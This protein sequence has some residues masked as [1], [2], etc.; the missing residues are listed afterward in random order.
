M[1]NT[2]HLKATT[3]HTGFRRFVWPLAT[4]VTMAVA[5]PALAQGPRTQGAKA[6]PTQ[7]SPGAG[8]LTWPAAPISDPHLL[9][10][11]IPNVPG[12]RARLRIKEPIGQLPRSDT[13]K[14]L[15]SNND[16]F[17][18]I[19][20]HPDIYARIN[21]V[22]RSVG[23][24]RRIGEQVTSVATYPIESSCVFDPQ[25][26][27]DGS[28]I[29]FKIGDAF[30]STGTF[31]LYLWDMAVGRLSEVLSEDISFSNVLWSPDS[32]YV[33]YVR[34]GDVAGRVRAKMLPLR[35]R[36]LDL[37]TGHSRHVAKSGGVVDMVWTQQG[38]L[39]FT[40]YPKHPKGQAEEDEP[41]DP[42]DPG[43][44]AAT[45]PQ[46]PPQTSIYE[47]PG[48]GGA[49]KL[50]IANG[51][52]PAPSPNGRWIAFIGSPDAAAG[53]AAALLSPRVYLFNRESRERV[54]VDLPG[55]DTLRWT[56]DSR[57]LVALD[58]SYRESAEGA[59]LGTAY[60]SLID[61]NTL[62]VKALAT[63]QAEDHRP[64]SRISLTAPQFNPIKFSK[65]GRYL[66]VRVSE[67]TGINVK[68]MVNTV[69]KTLRAV[70]LS[71][72]SVS[73]VA[74]FDDPMGRVLGFDWH[75][76]SG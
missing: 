34:G 51:Q 40:M 59:G 49:A 27:P 56:P 15:A 39:L 73:T 3:R 42:K 50:V 6:K 76:M 60:I 7:P 29:L 1:D 43:D 44:E 37:Q 58:E 12:A 47:A 62:K 23:V 21:F 10:P 22:L 24:T 36:V 30:D 61:P 5:H 64:M 38:T 2:P 45:G 71:T 33:A 65:D 41:K 4:F 72:G 18:G 63:L 13:L 53:E 68:A 11:Y 48:K 31:N 46:A 17:R 66:F 67:I 25:F 55:A 9:E 28:R 20:V 69:R 35:L 70:D 8:A 26:S 19:L 57:F 52:N 54:L 74:R 14:E 75:D 16:P 32:R